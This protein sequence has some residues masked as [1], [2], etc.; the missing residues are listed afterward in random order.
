MVQAIEP[1]QRS[2]S[3]LG[4][5]GNRHPQWLGIQTH[6]GKERRCGTRLLIDRAAQRLA[7]AHESVD[8][9]HLAGRAAGSSTGAVGP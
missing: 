5:L 8:A 4:G 2:V 1:R 6:L 3:G 9:I 7:N